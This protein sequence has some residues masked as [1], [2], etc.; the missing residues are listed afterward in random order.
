[1]NV[2]DMNVSY[3]DMTEADWPAIVE[4]GRAQWLDLPELTT[5][6]IQELAA[7]VDI[8]LCLKGASHGTVVID[9]ESGEVVGVIA[10]CGPEPP[11]RRVQGWHEIAIAKALERG[12]ALGTETSVYLRQFDADVR[13]MFV[14]G[15]AK[16]PRASEYDGRVALLILEPTYHGR[17]IGRALMEQALAWCKA[18]G[19]TFLCVDT[20]DTLNYRFY[21]SLGWKRAV[22]FPTALDVFGATHEANTLIYEYE[23]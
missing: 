9:E 10:Y 15:W 3:R 12:D 22:E 2:S 13:R 11:S 5:R 16:A 23:L 1:M 18:Q 21:E 17:G 6:E 20:D 4:L 14:E 7:I 8:H 19:S